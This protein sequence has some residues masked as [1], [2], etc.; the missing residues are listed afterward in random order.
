MEQHLKWLEKTYPAGHVSARGEQWYN[1]PFLVRSLFQFMLFLA[2]VLSLILLIATAWTNRGEVFGTMPQDP[3]L[4]YYEEHASRL[5]DGYETLS[6]ET[7]HPALLTLIDEHF[8][9]EL[10]AVLDVGAGTG[11]DA[12]WF[13]ANGHRTVAVEPSEAMQ[14]IGKRLHPS[15]DIE[16]RH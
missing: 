3:A 6:L 1:K 8:D 4:T 11:R 13:A 10:L 7:A 12:S 15:P 9:D 2:A 5:A 14:T 16:W